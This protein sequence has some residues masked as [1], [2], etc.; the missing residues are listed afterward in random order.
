MFFPN[1]ML[2][3]LT[4]KVTCIEVSIYISRL[5]ITNLKPSEGYLLYLQRKGSYYD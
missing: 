3:Y 1:F 5:C 2:N 4:Y